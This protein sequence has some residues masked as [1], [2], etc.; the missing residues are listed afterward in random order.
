MTHDEAIFRA[1][2]IKDVKYN[3]HISLL[4][5]KSYF[6]LVRIHFEIK[7]LP[8]QS[9]FLDYTGKVG[10]LVINDKE[11][12]FE[13]YQP[14]LEVQNRIYLENLALGSNSVEVSFMSD[15]S[16]NGLG[17]HKFTDKSDGNTYVYT[18]FEPD[19]CKEVIPSFDQPDL[20]A[21]FKL[22]VLVP[23]KWE[24]ISNEPQDT[25]ARRE[26]TV[27]LLDDVATKMKI[28]EWEA[29]SS[30]PGTIF[31]SFKQ[32]KVMSNYLFAII[33]G[34][35]GFIESNSTEFV[36]M[37]VYARQSLMKEVNLEEFIS[38]SQHGFRYFT[39][40]F[41]MPYQ[42]S[43]YDQIFLPEFS[44]GGMEQIG[45][46]TYNEKM[47]RR[48]ETPTLR[49][50]QATHLTTLHELSHM[51]FGNLVTMKWW[52]DLWLNESFATYMAYLVMAEVPELHYFPSPWGEF[53][54]RKYSGI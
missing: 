11:I 1:H 50:R 31:Y 51:W 18:K 6:G 28:S 7:S 42:F 9:L 15:Y 23:E 10:R 30:H 3:L 14:D 17:F 36:P 26:D 46:V 25:S 8:D 43:K 45:A 33:A 21:T 4:K 2:H 53:N 16:S 47:L 32:S 27:G 54:E 22:Q 12:P 29:F 41:G 52:N 24:A 34:P 48:G 13:F 20:K 35:F 38:V 39:D 44:S 5:G 49:K 37:R 19:H 40:L